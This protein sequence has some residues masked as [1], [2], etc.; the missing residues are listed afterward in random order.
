[1]RSAWLFLMAFAA[2]APSPPPVEPGA[3]R[4]EIDRADALI[5]EPIAIRVTGLTPG[6]S[7]TIL[8]RGGVND[9]WTANASFIAD[10]TGRIDLTQMAP[11]K[12]SYTGID[13]MGLFWSAE[14]TR[15]SPENAGADNNELSPEHWTLSAEAGGA[16]LARANI[17]RRA[18]AEGVHVQ[19]VRANGLVGDFYEPTGGGRHPAMLVL[20]GSGGGIP[21]ATG[22]AGGLSSRGYAVLAL[23]YFGVA[24]LPDNLSRI[25]IEYFGTALQWLAAQPSVDARRIGVLGA[26][27]GA[28]LALLL[29][30]AYPDIRAVVAY[31]PSNVVWRG[32]C[33]GQTTSIAWTLGGRPLATMPP[34]GRPMPLEAKRAEIE[35]EKIHGAVLLISGT[36][37]GV[38]ASAAMAGSIVARLK[39]AG[40]RYV[41]ESL[42]YEHAGHAISRP[43][44]PTT[45]LNGR[46]H[47]V[48][49]RIMQL[50]GTPAGTAKAREDSWQHVL[51]FVDR[52]L[53]ALSG[54][55]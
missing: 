28:E 51:A 21:P 27:R 7:V 48:S 30:V 35:V 5:D 32:C 4:F 43:Y 50:G 3:V 1:M 14:R 24:G 25:P 42:T 13:A 40:F 37:D 9:A 54:V 38:W 52:H 36:D 19:P 11:V 41:F 6:A 53:R 47:P 29:G 45:N 49:G 8:V 15:P 17:R 18:V 26:S 23:A 20:G 2:A 44:L 46:R 12:G 39:Q 22:P 34:P 10:S 33:G 55:S 16:V 31:M